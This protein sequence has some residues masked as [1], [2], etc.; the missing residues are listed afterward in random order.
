MKK[1]KAVL[2]LARWL[3]DVGLNA[4][5]ILDFITNA[6]QDED[7]EQIGLGLFPPMNKKGKHEWDPESNN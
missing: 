4:E 1:S 2:K 7:G 3:N 6:D 5:N